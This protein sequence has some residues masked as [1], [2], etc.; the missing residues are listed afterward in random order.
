MPSERDAQEA[1]AALERLLR[2]DV[3]TLEEARLAARLVTGRD[4][5]EFPP[6]APPGSPAATASADGS[7][8]PSSG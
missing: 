1:L 4:D 7:G 3:V 8:P 6:P 5:V 2:H